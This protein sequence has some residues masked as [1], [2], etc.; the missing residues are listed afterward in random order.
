MPLFDNIHDVALP[1]FLIALIPFISSYVYQYYDFERIESKKNGLIEFKENE[2]IL[3]Y[4]LSIK[5]DE[6]TNIEIGIVA[7]Y[8]E[9]INMVY[10]NPHEQKSLGIRNHIK[11]QTKSNEYGFH[12]K[13]ENKIHLKELE[14]TLF[15]LVKSEKLKLVE[16]KKTIK[17]VPKRFNMT[18]EYKGFIIKQIVEKRI[19]CT[20]GLLLHG[21]K[22]DK[23]AA[24]LRKKYCDCASTLKLL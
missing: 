14:N 24:E 9:R 3:D 19:N 4:S 17:L 16:P 7:Y 8:G 6:I 20:E 11:L 5:Y 23:E 10:R 12:F 2:I 22:T 15:E 21:Y 18:D 13:L 1:F